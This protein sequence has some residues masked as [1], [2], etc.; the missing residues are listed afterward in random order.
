VYGINEKVPFSETDCTNKPI[1]PYA[2]TKIAGEMLCHTYSSLYQ[3]STT[4]LRFF[5]VYG[6][7]QRPDLAIHR[8]IR[9]IQQGD[10]IPFY[11]DGTTERDYTYVEDIV[12]G[13]CAGLDYKA[14]IFSVFNLGNNATISLKH[15]IE[16]IENAMGRKAT[17]LSLP[18][19][20]GD[21]PRTWADI[22]RSQTILNYS[23]KIRIEE[24]IKN[25]ISWMESENS[26][27]DS[28]SVASS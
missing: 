28:H 1:S 27:L 22:S 23:P 2:T 17:I 14:E 13:I 4:A 6:P 21:V 7:R 18:S 9:M 25:F 20:P 12:D 15:L 8:F 5:T 16:T 10:P 3:I 26:R 24:G 19:Q 11:G